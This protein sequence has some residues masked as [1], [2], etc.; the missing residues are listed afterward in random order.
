MEPDVSIETSS[1][2]RVAVLQ[3]GTVSPAILRDHHSMLMRHY[4][5]PL[6]A[7]NSYRGIVQGKSCFFPVQ[8]EDGGKK[9]GN[10]ILFPPADCQTQEF[11]WQTMMQDI[12]ASLLMDFEKWVLKPESAGTI[13]MMPL[14]SQPSLS[15]TEVYV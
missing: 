12:A 5:I 9:R 2:I 11:H 10:L 3:I 14:D 15:S 8:L 4:T 6:S 7:I 1:M 13:I